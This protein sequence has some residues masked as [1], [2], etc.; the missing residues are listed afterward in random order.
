MVS[1]SIV[2]GWLAASLIASAGLIPIAR[3]L[4]TGQRASREAP[5][6]RV[7]VA[8]GLATGTVALGHTLTILSSLGSPAAVGGG[9]AAL[10]PGAL[11]FFLLFAHVGV[12]LQLRAPKL[13]DRV[14]KRRMHGAF[15]GAIVA[16]AVAHVVALRLYAGPG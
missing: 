7:H 1:L 8:L 3:R 5:P 2:S 10:A 13:R 9:N 4:Q 11:A 6:M 16:L 15:A 12:G 14:K